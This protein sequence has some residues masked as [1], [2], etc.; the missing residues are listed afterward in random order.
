LNLPQ[1]F[2][3]CRCV[4]REDWEAAERRFLSKKN[5]NGKSNGVTH[6]N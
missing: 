5:S 2:P 3:A 4:Q 1:S 6:G